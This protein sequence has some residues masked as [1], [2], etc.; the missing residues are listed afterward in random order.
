MFVRERSGDEDRQTTAEENYVTVLQATQNHKMELWDVSPTGDLSPIGDQD[1][2][3]DSDRL[4]MTT[5]SKGLGLTS[6]AHVPWKRAGMR[7]RQNP[8]V[9]PGK[10]YALLI[11]LSLDG[12]Y[13]QPSERHWES[14]TVDNET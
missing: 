13:N 3:P 10:R 12:E 5:A 7:T 14:E 9:R 6:K 11:A 4:T 1:G 2:N 8:K